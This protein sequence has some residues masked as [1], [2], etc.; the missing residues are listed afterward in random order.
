MKNYVALVS[1]IG[2]IFTAS[3]AAADEVATQIS[4]DYKF[5]GNPTSSV[6]LV[7]YSDGT[8][9]SSVAVTMQGST[10]KET[11]T[12][13]PLATG[14]Y[15]HGWISK[16]VEDNSI[17]LVIYTTRQS[18]GWSRITNPRIPFAKDIWGD[19]TGLPF[20]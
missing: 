6:A 5:M 13:V 20:H 7:V 12:A 17:E 14:E 2:L 1:F 10:H 19:C 4:C 16:E 3:L 18:Q 15:V 9:G 11:F 8:P